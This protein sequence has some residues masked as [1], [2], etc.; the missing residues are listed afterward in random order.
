MSKMD[1]ATGKHA[2]CE[3]IDNQDIWRCACGRYLWS[4]T[5]VA[6]YKG[7]PNDLIRYDYEP[8]IEKARLQ[9]EYS[10]HIKWCVS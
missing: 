10:R 5:E 1:C 4:G 6:Q 7:N 3:R 9:S 2:P 8:E